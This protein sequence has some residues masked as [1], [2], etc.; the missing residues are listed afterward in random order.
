[1]GR[2]SPLTDVLLTQDVGAKLLNF[3]FQKV[4]GS[5]TERV[6]RRKKIFLIPNSTQDVAKTCFQCSEPKI[7]T[8]YFFKKSSDSIVNRQCLK[9]VLYNYEHFYFL[10]LDYG[11]R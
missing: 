5:G 4:Q 7:E 3:F 2:P 1:M 9:I 6:K 8:F 10:L 11:E